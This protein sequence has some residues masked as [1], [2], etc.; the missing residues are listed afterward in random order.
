MTHLREQSCNACT[1]ILYHC[2]AE[3]PQLES[4]IYA[5]DAFLASASKM[6]SW[7]QA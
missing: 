2:P 4:Q 7:L 6:N 1:L 5:W 3:R